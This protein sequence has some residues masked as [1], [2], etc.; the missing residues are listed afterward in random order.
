[1]GTRRRP[2]TPLSPYASAAGKRLVPRRASFEPRPVA[3]VEINQ[4][5]GCISHFSAMARPRW[6]W[7]AV[8]NWHCHAIDRCRGDGVEDDAM[9]QRTRVPLISTQHDAGH[10]LPLAQ[11]KRQG[12]PPFFSVDQ[13]PAHWANQ[14]NQS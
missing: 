9:I 13:R 10:D 14:Y 2:Y 4:C 6:L 12:L 3:Y 1:M 11:A 5:V 8:R 7:R